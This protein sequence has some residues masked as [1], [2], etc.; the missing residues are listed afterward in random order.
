MHPRELADLPYAAALQPHKGGLSV[1]GD[2][3]TVHFDQVGFDDPDASNARFLECAFTRVTFQG[4]RLRRSRLRDVWLG[5]VRLTLTDLAET[6]WTD[7]TFSGGVAAGVKAFG[8]TLRKV[9]FRG[10]KLDSVNFRDAE[11]TDVIF[12]NCLLRDVDFAMAKLTRTRFA[13]SRLSATDFTGASM[14]KVDL[15]GAELGIVIGPDSLR[16]AI[17]STSQ[18]VDIAPVLAQSAGLIVEDY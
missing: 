12:E 5:D 10:C 13:D 8:A 3:D 4:G 7:V 2:Y 16:G 14:D 11:L 15:R 6:Q 1:A 17:I 18:L 9:A